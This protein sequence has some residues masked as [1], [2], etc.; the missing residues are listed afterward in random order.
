MVSGSQTCTKNVRRSSELG[1]GAPRVYS[2]PRVSYRSLLRCV[3][4]YWMFFN[5]NN[6]QRDRIT[7]TVLNRSIIRVAAANPSVM[8]TN[9]LPSPPCAAWE[10]MNELEVVLS[11]WNSQVG[12]LN[13]TLKGKLPELLAAAGARE[14][15]RTR[16]GI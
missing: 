5:I 14:L 9:K 1:I 3:D 2:L 10:G 12:L 6:T 15:A 11:D 13:S 16:W 7:F 8:M 4:I